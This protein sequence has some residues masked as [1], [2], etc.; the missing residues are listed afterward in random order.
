MLR[1][2]LP[3]FSISISG[4]L[5]FGPLLYMCVLRNVMLVM[6]RRRRRQGDA[7][8][9]S[10]T[11]KARPKNLPWQGN[12][13]GTR[14]RLGDFIRVDKLR[15]CWRRTAPRS[16]FSRCRPASLRVG[17]IAYGAARLEGDGRW[18]V[19]AGGHA[20][21]ERNGRSFSSMRAW[22]HSNPMF[23]R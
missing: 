12:H 7:G 15:S 5:D 17:V 23:G 13:G 18:F 14:E 3:Y 9:D 11:T 19:T 20:A 21:D 8:D 16:D 22:L 10:A 1:F 6:I 2:Y 4:R